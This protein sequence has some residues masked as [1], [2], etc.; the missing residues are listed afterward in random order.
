VSAAPDNAQSV[1]RLMILCDRYP[2]DLAS[3]R[4]LRMHHLCRQLLR[5][6]ECYFVEFAGQAGGDGGDALEFADRRSLPDRDRADRS[7]LRHLRLS[8]GRLIERAWPDYYRRS[9]ASLRELAGAWSPDGLVCLS[10]DHGEFAIELG[11]PVVLDGCD[12]LTLTKRRVLD[13]RGGE[14]GWSERQL[15]RLDLFRQAR[16]ER[17]LSRH[18]DCTLA[19]A[20]P[21]REEYLRLSGVRPERVQVVPN[22]VADAA[23]AAGEIPAAP[24]RSVAFWGNLDFPPNWTAVEYFHDRIFLPHLAEAGVS[25]F[26]YGRGAGS[27][28]RR[29]AEHP[30]IHLH[31]YCGNLFETVRD[32]GVMVN[33]MIEGSGLKN[34]VLESFALRL[35]VV[36][37]TLGVEALPV[38]D[39]RECRIA[40]E[41]REFAR[42]VLALLDDH[43]SASSMSLAARAFVTEH[44]TWDAVGDVLNGIVASVLEK[45]TAPLMQSRAS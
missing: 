32:H 35:P 15:A 14:M 16:R 2:A 40:D 13:N 30:L 1:K 45:R 23:L 38:T 9:L 11:L 6:F 34:K 37:T 20:E 22:G 21:D 18:V 29:F 27:R 19:I 17:R 12:C 26:I 28:I 4:Y 33:P 5:A 3:G 41:P 39:G 36:S 31:G 10:G 43:E 7:A 44:Y 42:A 25:W 8:N 24:T